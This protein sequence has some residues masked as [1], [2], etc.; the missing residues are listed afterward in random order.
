MDDEG[1]WEMEGGGVVR[2]RGS[3]RKIVV[4]VV[5]GHD[6]PCRVGDGL[7]DGVDVWGRSRRRRGWE[8]R[9]WG[10]GGGAT[11]RWGWGWS[12]RWRRGGGQGRG[13]RVGVRGRGLGGEVAWGVNQWNGGRGEEG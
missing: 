1:W 6:P 7:L 4:W 3:E 9:W 13:G 2:S 11:R 10:G 5:E 8:G 12:R